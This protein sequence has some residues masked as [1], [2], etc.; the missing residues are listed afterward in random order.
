MHAANVDG[1]WGV[2]LVVGL[3]DGVRGARAREHGGDDHDRAP[4]RARDLRLLGGTAGHADAHGGAR[5]AADRRWRR[6]A[7]ERPS[8]RSR[9]PASRGVTASRSSCRRSSPPASWPARGARPAGRR[10]RR[11]GS[12]CAPRPRRR[13]ARRSERRHTPSVPEAAP[14]RGRLRTMHGRCRRVGA[15]TWCWRS[16]ACPPCIGRGP[17]TH[18]AHQ[19]DAALVVAERSLEE[20]NDDAE[21]TTVCASPLARLTDQSSVYAAPSLV[22]L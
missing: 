16:V 19:M 5:D 7:R 4:R 10:G 14:D 15:S 18:R 12:R 6:W 20:S 13:C 21:A 2:W 3:A 8:S 17:G 9:S 1:S 22:R 11:P